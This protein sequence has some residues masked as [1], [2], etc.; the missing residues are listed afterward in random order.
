MKKQMTNS[1]YLEKETYIERV[2]RTSALDRTQLN[3]LYTAT[4]QAAQYEAF[5]SEG[6]EF[7]LL[8]GK[9]K[10]LESGQYI[11]IPNKHL[12]ALLEKSDYPALLKAEETRFTD[13]IRMAMVGTKDE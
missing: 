4:L 2:E 9:V 3:K 6:R 13:L 11:F 12:R 1:D 5:A 7:H 8:E 10:Q